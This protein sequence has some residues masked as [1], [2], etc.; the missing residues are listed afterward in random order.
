MIKQNR[1]GKKANVLSEVTIFTIFAILIFSLIYLGLGRIGS[2]ASF[3][4]QVYAKQI[5]LVIDKA[6]PGMEI[7]LDVSGL[8]EI[9]NKNNFKGE[10]VTIDN[11][12]NNVNVCLVSGKC[13]EFNYFSDL[14]IVWN[15]EKDN[16]ILYMKFIGSKK[17]QEMIL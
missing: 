1:I 8:Y 17:V 2:Q 6:E 3:Y 13:Y 10:I 11:K 16:E 9:A 4:E 15:L 14:D 5:A 12:A 7:N